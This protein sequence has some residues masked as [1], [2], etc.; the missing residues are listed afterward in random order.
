MKNDFFTY[1]RQKIEKDKAAGR[2][3]V[4]NNRGAALKCLSKFLGKEELT[5]GELSPEM[6]TQFKGW[7]KSNWTQGINRPSLFIPDSYPLQRSGER[8]HCPTSAVVEWHKV[9]FAIQTEMRVAFGGG[10]AK[11]ALC[12]PFILHVTDICP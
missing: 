2:C 3:D 11:D 7:L 9:A 4:A 8:R 5:F 12:R 1:S 10:F 6:M